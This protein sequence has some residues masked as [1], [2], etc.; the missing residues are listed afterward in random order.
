M[1][2]KNTADERGNGLT[3]DQKNPVLI[4]KVRHCKARKLARASLPAAALLAIKPQAELDE[5][6]EI[7]GVPRRT[8]ALAAL[9]L[10]S[11]SASAARREES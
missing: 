2:C 5:A 10:R 9:M 8:K 11:G 6:R 4:L 1:R 3:R 7:I